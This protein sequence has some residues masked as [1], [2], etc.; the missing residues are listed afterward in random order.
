M[1]QTKKTMKK[2]TNKSATAKKNN[3]STQTISNVENKW[4]SYF[5]QSMGYNNRFINIGGVYNNDPYL[6]NQRIKQLKTV[7]TF[8]E[9]TTIEDSL[10]NPTTNEQ[11]LRT[12]T[13]SALYLTY[14]LYRLQYMYE[15]ILTYRN[16]IQ[17]I[18]VDKKEMG[19]EKFKSE[20]KFIDKWL[21]Q[22]NPQKQFRRIVAEVIP[23]GKRAYYLRQKCNNAKDNE[24]VDYV[25]LQSLPSDWYK[26][27][28]HSTSNYFVVAFNFAYFWQSGTSLE[29]FPPIFTEYFEELMGLVQ[30]SD[31]GTK[32]IDI[33]CLPNNVT[34][35]YNRETQWSYWK[36]LPT[37]DCFVFSFTEAD[38]L[39]ISPFSS[40]LLQSQDLNSYA[41]LQQQLLSVPLYSLILG[42]V[43]LHT[44]NKGAN[45]TDDYRL[46]PEAVDGFEAKINASM[47]PGTTYTMTPSVENKLYHFEAIPNANDIYD[48]GLQQMINTAGA[49]TLM[50]TTSKPS[51]SQVN[52]GK[53]LE[54][55]FIDRIYEQ[56]ATFVNSTL[57][58][59]K[60]DGTLKY[61]WNFK[62]FGDCFSEKDQI[63][64]LEKSLS[65]G[66]VGNYQMYLA[67]RNKSL[68]DEMCS[69]DLVDSCGMYDRF[70]PLVNSYTSSNVGVDDNKA[71]RKPIDESEIDNDSTASSIDSGTNISR[72]KTQSKCSVCQN[73][74]YYNDYLPFC[75][76]ECYE[77][78]NNEEVE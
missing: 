21:K 34:V 3:Q 7:P 70:K 8:L 55:R 60:V 9:R 69:A 59:M 40:L 39:Q 5:S 45:E 22:L 76:Q 15:G 14:P 66:Q 68:L 65:L 1:E 29:Q 23:E 78:H 2:S 56:F 51:V 71:G 10:L 38:D 37:E 18:Y 31:N 41:L 33:N 19:S 35:E 73:D 48:K 46:S 25:H 53:I 74:I 30:I 44:E 47:P 43:P 32:I 42:E 72:N 27:I 67:Y 75:S 17:P 36:E 20:L 50:T 52:S 54:T 49:S 61:D 58:N 11:Q 63:M 62:I 57:Y 24:R 13:Q 28:K 26:I 77:S 12:A 4:K 16:Y 6:L 64:S